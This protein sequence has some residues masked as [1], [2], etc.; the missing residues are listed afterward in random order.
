MAK[1]T[2]KRAYKY[3]FYPTQQQE[4]L[5]LRTFGCVRLVW[6]RM[7]EHRTTAWHQ[8]R[9]SVSYVESSKI[10]TQWKHDPELAFLNEVSSVPLAQSLR[11]L[12][13]ALSRFWSKQNKYPRFKSRKKS[14]KSATFTQMA[15]RLKQSKHGSPHPEI[16]LAK[17]D[18][19]LDIVWS[20]SLPEGAQPS[21]VTVSQDR[22]GR[23]FVSL[24]VE[25][26]IQQLEPLDARE[27]AI[28]V[29]MGLH[30]LAI[31]S[32]GEKI[33]NPRHTARD[34]RAL[35][36][37][38]RAHAR[39]QKGSNNREKARLKVARIQ[40][41]TSDR[42]KDFL[43]KLTTSMIRENQTI[44]IE[45]LAVQN[46]SR[47]SKSGG[48]HKKGLNRA[49]LDASWS[50]LRSQLEYKAAWYGRDVVVLSQWFP[51]SQLCSA[52]GQQTGPR[53]DLAMR[54]WKCS[55]CGAAHDRDVNAAKNVLAA[56]LAAS[57]CGDGRS[58]RWAQASA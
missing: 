23:W 20:R 45:D 4:A 30:H 36:R 7:L 38:Q 19:P 21:S 11:H 56:G 31:L 10:L 14:R 13:D 40:A 1:R 16:W 3:R 58:L 53:G 25:E 15:F 41:R 18:A 6:N 22:A 47:R 12:Q 50:E 17:C 28:G 5:L 48:S 35:A 49:I 32:T 29:D 42:R 8:E 33:S 52:C 2:V 46:M 54:S 55:A 39:K 34:A 37:A 24:L 57:V 44:V 51:S 27:H 43:H 9:R 26:Q